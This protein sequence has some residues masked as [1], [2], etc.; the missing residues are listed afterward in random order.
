MSTIGGSHIVKPIVGLLQ[1]ITE[2]S[3]IHA[4]TSLICVLSTYWWFA[5]WIFQY[6]NCNCHCTATTDFVPWNADAHSTHLA[7]KQFYPN[8]QI[9][10]CIAGRRHTWSESHARWNIWV[11][12]SLG[13]YLKQYLKQ[14]LRN[15]IWKFEKPFMGSHVS[16][17]VLFPSHFCWHVFLH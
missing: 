14:A 8:W 6:V 7:Q 9:Y 3:L 4:Q 12:L 11:D 16:I 17:I 5:W 10:L 2:N 15:E 1:Y 13:L